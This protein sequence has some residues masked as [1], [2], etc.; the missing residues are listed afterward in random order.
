MSISTQLHNNNDDDDNYSQN[1]KFNG[2]LGCCDVL[3]KRNFK[4][5]KW[6]GSW[7]KLF[8]MVSYINSKK[9]TPCTLKSQGE[10]N[11]A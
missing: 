5:M 1:S 4:A 7:S 9:K 11:K 10:K 3:K 2:I 8:H 6:L